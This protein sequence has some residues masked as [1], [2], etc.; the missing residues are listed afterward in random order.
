MCK[1][2]ASQRSLQL[3][4]KGKSSAG[5]SRVWPYLKGFTLGLE[6]RLYR[7]WPVHELDKCQGGHQTPQQ[8]VGEACAKIR[9]KAQGKGKK[10]GFAM[11]A[12]GAAAA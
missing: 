3:N 4:A 8:L 7:L 5:L 10:C 9:N 2:A 1:V 6:G 11:A 12:H